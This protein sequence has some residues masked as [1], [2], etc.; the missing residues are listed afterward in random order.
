MTQQNPRW[1][2]EDYEGAF[3]AL[4]IGTHAYESDFRGDAVYIKNLVLPWSGKNLSDKDRVEWLTNVLVTECG[5][6]R[7]LRDWRAGVRIYVGYQNRSFF[8]T[9][10]LGMKHYGHQDKWRQ[11]FGRR[12][13]LQLAP[14]SHGKSRI[15][16]FELPI[17]TICYQDNA[18][19][20]HIT[21]VEGEAQKYLVAV[22]TQFEINEKI[23]YDFGDLTKD[24]DDQGL[25]VPLD[26][27]WSKSM[28]F[29]R[30]TNK[31]LK[32]PTL[33]AIGSGQAITGARFD[34]VIAD[35]IIEKDDSDTVEKREDT[36]AWW[37]AVILE[38]LDTDGWAL[39]IGTRKNGDDLYERTINKPTWTY[40]VD[41]AII[42]YPSHYN[43]VM[44]PDENCID[45]LERIEHSGDGIVLA[46]D[47]WSI[48]K[49]L[50]KKLENATT[51]WVFDR[52]QQQEIT[53]EKNKIFQKIWM[54][55]NDFVFTADGNIM[56]LTD[57]QV[58][59]F[60]G[61]VI[62]DGTDLARSK[63]D[64]ADYFVD[65]TIAMDYHFNAYVLDFVRDRYTFDE[66]KQKITGQ[67][68]KWGSQLV[69]IEDVAY[70]DVMR[71]HLT[72][73]SEVPAVAVKRQSDKV[74]RGLLVQPYFQNRKVFFLKGKMGLLKGELN[75]FPDGAHDDM[76]DALETAISLGIERVRLAKDLREQKM[77]RAITVDQFRDVKAMEREIGAW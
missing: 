52:E 42:K 74:A 4:T 14:R 40:G 71:Q 45:K 66:Q 63:K 67:H 56:R 11:N 17:R 73:V 65:I 24:L 6:C 2:S 70:Q 76:F 33:Q 51:P 43:F 72:F 20:L 59:Q 1:T 9:H 34:G 47:M 29:V 5:Y 30:R 44:K 57:N 15:Y 35:D 49:I 26:S 23:R 28:F 54:D 69:G 58:V 31:T 13:H 68:R 18:R 22:R 37:N 10:Y 3:Y 55:G 48:E 77:A 41:K 60:E 27:T 50:E 16:S 19:L 8:G 12:R 25:E 38:L 62:I 21:N 7:P 39:M 36:E 61:L 32:D 64:S 53:E 46:P 75:D